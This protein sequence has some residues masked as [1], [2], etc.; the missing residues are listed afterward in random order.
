MQ[1]VACMLQ[2][3]LLVRGVVIS[4]QMALLPILTTVY[5]IKPKALHRFVGY[6]EETA[7]C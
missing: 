6:L 5:I 3:S 1:D 4:A 7:V 2:P